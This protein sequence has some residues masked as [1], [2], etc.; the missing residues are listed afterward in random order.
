MGKNKK[1]KASQKQSAQLRAIEMR[2]VLSDTC[3]ACRTPCSRGLSY[4]KRMQEPGAVGG[5]VPC[6]LTRKRG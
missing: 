3:E 5:G 6:V 4:L 2:I 1:G